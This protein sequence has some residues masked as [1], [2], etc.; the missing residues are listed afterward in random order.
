MYS[1]SISLFVLEIL[2]IRCRTTWC[3]QLDVL[4]IFCSF[5][6]LAR[7]ENDERKTSIIITVCVLVILIPGAG[8]IVFIIYRRRWR[9]TKTIKTHDE[10]TGKAVENTEETDAL[11]TWSCSHGGE[12]S[13]TPETTLSRVRMK[14]EWGYYPCAISTRH[15]NTRENCVLNVQDGVQQNLCFISFLDAFSF[16]CCSI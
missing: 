6:S 12:I 15:N 10:E 5:T 9:R 1:F 2:Q 4:H 13:R 7:V 11:K 3:N 16:C 8:I 14:I